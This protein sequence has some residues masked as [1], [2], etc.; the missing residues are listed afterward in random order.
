MLVV[1][2]SW[3][4]LYRGNLSSLLEVLPRASVASARPPGVREISSVAQLRDVLRSRPPA[5]QPL[6]TRL[7]WWYN[8][9]NAARLAELAAQHARAPWARL[10]LAPVPPCHSLAFVRPARRLRAA[11]LP[12]LEGTCAAVHLRL[13]TRLRWR[14]S[15]DAAA[16]P[17]ATARALLACACRGGGGGGRVFVSADSD[18]TLLDLARQLPPGRVV[19]FAE[20]TRRLQ[21][22][23]GEAATAC[24]RGCNRM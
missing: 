15:C 24:S 18:A 14:D 11:A 5:A 13:C 12:L 22:H 17:A 2:G 3:S 6:Y 19:S 21:P 4:T 8:T 23:V 10:F 9:G 7:D 16:D 20:V 1:D